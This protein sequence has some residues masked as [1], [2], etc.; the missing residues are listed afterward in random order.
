MHKPRCFVINC[1]FLYHIDL[2]INSY[3]F[4]LPY[5]CLF[6]FFVCIISTEKRV[7]YVRT[8]ECMIPEFTINS[9]SNSKSQKS[10]NSILI[11]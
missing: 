8:L 2:G 11:F 9:N 10:K 3:L 4:F 5:Y 7:T 6:I 1:T